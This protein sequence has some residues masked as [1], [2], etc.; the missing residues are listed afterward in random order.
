VSEI[1]DK[2]LAKGIAAGDAILSIDNTPVA[3]AEQRLAHLIAASTP[4]ALRAALAGRLLAGPPG[5]TASLL[6]RGATG[7]PRT[8]RLMRTTAARAVPTQQ[9]WRILPGNVGYIDLEY[10]ARDE[11]GPALAELMGTKAIVLD[12]RNGGGPGAAWVLGPYLAQANTPY[13]VARLRR[14]SYQ[15]PPKAEAP[16]AAWL[17]LDDIQRPAARNRYPGRVFVLIDERTA[18]PAEHAALIFKAA[19]AVTFVGSPTNGTNGDTTA[20]RLPGGLA[21]RFSAHD[22]R[23]GDGAKL[24][25]VGIQPN[26]AAA[27]TVRGL[28]N[29][30]DDV[31]EKALDLARR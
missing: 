21:L 14:P 7:A 8:V 12:L 2:T 4:Q 19:T 22:V 29:G 1:V 18:G 11:A 20:L 3:I 28:R 30:R 13:R 25:R 6:V 16:E 17:A 9:A 27:P 23:Q 24:Q 10:L 26:V 5:S 31:L 15:G